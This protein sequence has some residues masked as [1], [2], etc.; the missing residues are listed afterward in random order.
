MS[1]PDYVARNRAVW[2]KT[3]EEFTDAAAQR[4]ELARARRDL[5]EMA[6]LREENIRL[7]QTAAAADDLNTK[8]AQLTR[9]NEQLTS[10]MNG[11]RADLDKAL[12]HSA[13]VEKQLAEAMTVRTEGG[14]GMRKLQ[15]DLADANR[16]VD[17]L[18]G[19]VADLTAAN[20]KLEKDL[21][22][23]QKSTAAAL[24]AQSQA[25]SAASPDSYQMELGTLNARIKQLESQVEDE[26]TSAATAPC[27]AALIAPLA[28]YATVWL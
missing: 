7:R 10:F 26:R 27:R 15:A 8:N 18:N 6:T 19:T 25:V 23:A 21:D 5:V 14:Q 9:D 13:E 24:A 20:E 3:N 1:E 28:R 2:T 4:E 16:T 22:S 12:A 17:K 11:N